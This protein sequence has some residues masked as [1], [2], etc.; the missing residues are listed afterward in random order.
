MPPLRV[1]SLVAGRFFV[2]FASADSVAR[3]AGKPWA[4]TTW[5]FYLEPLEDGRSRF[6]S[7]FRC[8]Y[9]DDLATQLALTPTL[10]EPIGFAMDRRMLKGIKERAERKSVQLKKMPS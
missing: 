7:R 5:L 1:V 4:E 10:L 6:V 2:A 8:N 9:S 3:A